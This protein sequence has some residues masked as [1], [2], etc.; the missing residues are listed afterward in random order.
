[1]NSGGGDPVPAGLR[2]HWLAAGGCLLLAVALLLPQLLLVPGRDAGF[3]MYAGQGILL[4]EVP[5]RDFWDHK[6]PLVYV[7]YALGLLLAGG[8]WWGVWTLATVSLT[9]AG[10]LSWSL[11]RPLHGR[12]VAGAVTVIWMLGLGYLV[13]GSLGTEL[14][15]LILQLGALVLLPRWLAEPERRRWPFVLGVL[16]GLAFLM[17]QN[18]VGTAV[19]VFAGGAL[20]GAG[21]RGP[22]HLLRSALLAAAGAVAA[23]APVALYFAV[24]GSLTAMW[25]AAFY[26]NMLYTGPGISAQ[27]DAVAFGIERV[28][29]SYGALLVWLVIVVRLAGRRPLPD[30]PRGAL[31]RVALIAVPLECYLA[32]ASGKHYPHYFVTWLPA[33]AILLAE[34]LGFLARWPWPH[35]RVAARWLGIGLVV[36]AIASTRYDT[37]LQQYAAI[38]DPDADRAI[39]R[40]AAYLS[41]HTTPGQRSLTW[42]ADL[43][44]LALADRRSS[45]RFVYQYPLI[46]P[47]YHRDAVTREFLAEFEREPPAVIIDQGHLWMPRLDA[48]RR[49]PVE[50]P[51]YR[52]TRIYGPVSPLLAPFFAAVDTG[53]IHV[54]T[55]DHVDIFVRKR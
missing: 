18:H 19:A 27:L 20:L 23:V 45:S 1:V 34:L 9:G 48:A 15:T 40:A 37:L 11:L 8:G 53:Y 4:G 42:G 22:I 32:T 31:L 55:I 28:P 5:Y 30:G 39:K 47:A 38:D 33:L 10:W 17:R 3:F 29:W 51:A 44:V 21:W 2:E 16:A 41:E 36:A 13:G 46:T 43:A 49:Q 7:V 26:Y 54:E 24:T 12:A 25:D 14:L 35:G 6:P 52:E 50:I